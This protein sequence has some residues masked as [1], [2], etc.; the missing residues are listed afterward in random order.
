[1]DNINDILEKN[2]AKCEPFKVPEGYF[3]NFEARLNA[4]IDELEAQKTETQGGVKME[5]AKEE[6]KKSGIWLT[7]KPLLYVAACIVAL[8]AATYIIV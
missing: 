6:P 3:E 5:P 7:V 2:K 1:M 8:Y 4:R